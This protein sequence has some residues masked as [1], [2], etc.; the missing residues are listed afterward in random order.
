MVH[1]GQEIAG[2]RLIKKI[3]EGGMGQVFLAEQLRLHRQVAIKLVYLD[4]KPETPSSFV[5]PAAELTREAQALMALEHPHILALY[6][7]GRDGDTA[8]LVM[9]YLPDGSLQDALRPGPHQQLQLPLPPGEALIYIEQAAA[10]LQYAHDR[11]F[12]HR[13]VKPANFLVRSLSQTTKGERTVKRLHLFLADF[14]L[15]KFLAYSTVTKHVSGTPTFM[16][17]EQFQGRAGPASDQYALAVLLYYLLTGDLPYRGS[18]IELMFHHLNDPPPAPSSRLPSL[19]AA[20]DRVVQRGMAK[21]PET[22]H[23]SVMSLAEAAREALVAAGL[24]PSQDSYPALPA[25][26]VADLQSETSSPQ[27][28]APPKLEPIALAPSETMRAG[29]DAPAVQSSPGGSASMQPRE[30]VLPTVI[31]HGEVVPAP[32]QGRESSLPTLPSLGDFVPPPRAPGAEP[33]SEGRPRRRGGLVAL[34]ALV[35]VVL[36]GAVFG[37]GYIFLAGQHHTAGRPSPTPTATRA[38][39]AI[40]ADVLLSRTL[41][42]G[43]LYQVDMTQ[44][45]GQWDGPFPL[46][47]NAFYN[48]HTPGDAVIFQN[49]RITFNARTFQ[50]PLAVALELKA[51]ADQEF[52]LVLETTDGSGAPLAY[53]VHLLSGAPPQAGH[54]VGNSAYTVDGVGAAVNTAWNNGSSHTLIL[55]LDGTRLLFYLNQ[56]VLLHTQVP[57]PGAAL[58]LTLASTNQAT[59]TSIKFYSVPS[60]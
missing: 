17:P 58:K 47:P 14:G 54:S 27:A 52:D 5:E 19:P 3:G 33:P 6:D 44:G 22:R 28:S 59:V 4:V 20:L 21:N 51:G 57:L 18:P 29:A 37:G 43:P 60:H 13:D 26:R 38:P 7:T 36:V 2:Y 32:A 11:N 55:L 1:D 40:P 25:V 35:A 9:P 16:A 15:S 46:K 30:S 45:S 56:Q 8:Y 31:S 53:Q 10:A 24:A 41:A 50:P 49:A 39:T 34:V 48:I 23:P 42:Q 12:I